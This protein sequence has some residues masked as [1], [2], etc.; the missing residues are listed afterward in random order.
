MCD[1]SDG[2]EI[3]NITCTPSDGDVIFIHSCDTT[4][5][6]AN[7]VKF[8]DC[9]AH[10]N[11]EMKFS[12]MVAAD[13][14]HNISLAI[15]DNASTIS[16]N[17]GGDQNIAIFLDGAECTTA[18]ESALGHCLTTNEP[19]I[20][21]TPYTEILSPGQWHCVEIRSCDGLGRIDTNL[22]NKVYIES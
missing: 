12:Y 13:H 16:N 22:Y 6:S 21:L 15:T 9:C 18:I 20:S 3:A 10:R 2:E 1:I 4:D 8:V 19:V 14:C 11:D 7:N 17:S 5:R